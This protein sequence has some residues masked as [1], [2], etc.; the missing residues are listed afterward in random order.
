[1]EESMANG[2]RREAYAQEEG[3]VG[4]WMTLRNHEGA[5]GMAA[6]LSCRASD[7]MIGTGQI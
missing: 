7:R 3:Q 2:W 6:G 1:M 4:C 5:R